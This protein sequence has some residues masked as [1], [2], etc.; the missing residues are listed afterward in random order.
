VYQVPA[1]SEYAFVFFMPENGNVQNE[2]EEWE[3]KWRNYNKTLLASSNSV[4]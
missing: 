1:R 3:E 2:Q 4:L